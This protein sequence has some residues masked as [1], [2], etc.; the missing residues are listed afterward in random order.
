[1]AKIDMMK[2]N[3]THKNILEGNQKRLKTYF[4]TFMHEKYCKIMQVLLI[5]G[6]I[7]RILHPV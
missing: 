3:E 4:G 1:M 2:F 5:S 7:G 6:K